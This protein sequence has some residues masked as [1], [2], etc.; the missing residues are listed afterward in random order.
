M[1]D[2]P[3]VLCYHAVSDRW[4]SELAVP[5]ERLERQL[6]SLLAGGYRAVTFSE[7]VAA[8]QAAKLLAVTFDD[9]FQ[10]VIDNGFPVLERLGVP[11]TVFT[12]TA[13]VGG[14]TLGWPGIDQWLDGPFADE[15][16][17]MS[18]G[19]LRFLAD[20]GW[21]IG[22]HTC[23]HPH[24]T[25]ISDEHV[26][27][28]LTESRAALE[29][30]LGRRCRSLAYP[31]GAVD[32]RVAAAAEAVGYEAAATLPIGFGRPAALTWPRVGIY[33]TDGRWR[34]RMKVS[35]AGRSL[36][37]TPA[38][39]AM[40]GIN[41]VALAA[42]RAKRGEA[43]PAVLVTNAEER[44][45][46]AVTRALGQGGYDVGAVAALRPA[47]AHWSRFCTERVSAPD[48]LLD[49]D[50][51][52]ERLVQTVRSGRYSIL[53]P[54]IDPALLV[55]SKHRA[56]LQP[57]VRMGL[58]PHPTVLRTL[59]KLALGTSVA[60]AGLVVPETVL[61]TNVEEALVAARRFGFPVALKPRSS[62]FE[63]D[64]RFRHLPGR[65]VHDEA[66]LAH[67]AP[68][69]GAEYLIQACETGPLSSYGGVFAD[70]RVLA[71]VLSRVWRT[72]RPDGGGIAFSRTVAV[73]SCV[74][75]TTR[76]CSS[77]S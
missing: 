24:L 48:P 37:S 11:G 35:R 4:P 44:S 60:G 2:G 71:S 67:V 28:E 56:L 45:I 17:P 49:E 29:A 75:P 27:N 57:Y 50:R 5:A 66:E 58:P 41:R 33:R 76:D 18:W 16:A 51:Y 47:A 34:F 36:R 59:D 53:M 77:L 31:F 8:P 52:I 70:G 68:A 13:F 72:V 39:E 20:A 30:E 55:I 61:C 12:P 14:Q 54:G 23:S 73:A 43:K 6:R 25:E 74:E 65:L 63:L 32:P 3:L 64:G 46:L 38:A 7:A 26:A 1:T 19:S 69:Y 62:A 21:E 15:L 42:S 40:V 22:S 9:G 10:S